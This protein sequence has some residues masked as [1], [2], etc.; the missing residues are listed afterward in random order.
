MDYFKIESQKIDKNMKKQESK[1]S[2][3]K[4]KKNFTC[5]N[6]NKIN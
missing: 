3:Q 4:Q 2:V 6:R 5:I 1:N